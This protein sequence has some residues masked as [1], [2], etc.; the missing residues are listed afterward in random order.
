M[1]TGCEMI[2]SW[3]VKEGNLHVPLGASGWNF[4]S[5]NRV[6]FS[7]NKGLMLLVIM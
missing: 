7:F 4:V 1:E 5:P 6:F 3:A 2:K